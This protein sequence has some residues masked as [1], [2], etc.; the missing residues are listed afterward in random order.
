MGIIPA[1]S[2]FVAGVVGSGLLLIPTPEPLLLLQLR[3]Q[4]SDPLGRACSTLRS[5]HHSFPAKSPRSCSL[6]H[7]SS[8]TVYPLASDLLI[9]TSPQPPQPPF[10]FLI[11][12]IPCS[13]PFLI[14]VGETSLSDRVVTIPRR[15]HYLF[16]KRDLFYTSTSPNSSSTIC[17]RSFQR[18]VSH[19]ES[20]SQVWARNSQCIVCHFQ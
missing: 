17:C 15:N 4:L 16:P 6:P 7:S 18:V 1:C 10:C 20:R 19:P 14:L 5:T 8:I 11:Y 12:Q 2:Q 3:A 9:Q 13:V